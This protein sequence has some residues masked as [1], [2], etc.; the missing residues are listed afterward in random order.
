MLLHFVRHA[1]VTS[2]TDASIEASECSTKAKKKKNKTKLT[3]SAEE[4]DDHLSRFIRVL[5][6]FRT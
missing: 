6:Y 4:K 3:Q 2:C 5:G 1:T